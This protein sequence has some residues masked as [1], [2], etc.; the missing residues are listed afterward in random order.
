[1]TVFY[2]IYVKSDIRL[3]LIGFNPDIEHFVDTEHQYKSHW[4]FRMGVFILKL[5][6]KI[7]FQTS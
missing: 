2:K 1:M 3:I 5:L 4:I 7:I 6:I